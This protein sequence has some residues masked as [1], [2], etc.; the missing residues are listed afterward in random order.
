MQRITLTV[1]SKNDAIRP[2]EITAGPTSIRFF[3]VV[4]ICKP[5]HFSTSLS[6]L[7]AYHQ[8]A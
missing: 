5:K 8:V 3:A 4:T 6:P 1:V 7:V 2:N